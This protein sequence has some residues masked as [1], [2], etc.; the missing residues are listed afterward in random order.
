MKI[1]HLESIGEF[2]EYLQGKLKT[3]KRVSEMVVDN[4]INFT[5]GT[6][7]NLLE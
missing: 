3:A 7:I 6:P 5:K 2:P 4:V 1:L